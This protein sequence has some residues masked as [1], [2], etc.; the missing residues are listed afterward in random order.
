M[1]WVIFGLLFGL[2]GLATFGV[3]ANVA[4]RGQ[5]QAV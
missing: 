4:R 5:G 3:F 2:T 1:E